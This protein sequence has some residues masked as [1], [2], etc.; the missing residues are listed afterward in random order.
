LNLQRHIVQRVRE[1]MSVIEHQRVELEEQIQRAETLRQAIL[2]RAFSG[3]LVPQ[4]P[5][6]EPACVL[7]ERIRTEMKE[8]DASA[9]GRRRKNSKKEA[10]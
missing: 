8:A 6:D 7:L 2:K 5:Q 10:A 3:Q 1:R 9:N 4:D